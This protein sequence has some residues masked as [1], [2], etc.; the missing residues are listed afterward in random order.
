MRAPAPLVQAEQLEGE[1][2]AVSKMRVTEESKLRATL[3]A[4]EEAAEAARVEA[5]ANA[6]QRLAA[7]QAHLEEMLAKQRAELEEDL[8]KQLGSKTAYLEGKNQALEAELDQL[9]AELKKYKNAEKLS[10]KSLSSAAAQDVAAA[11]VRRSTDCTCCPPLPPLSTSAY[12]THLPKPRA[13]L[14]P[15]HL[16]NPEQGTGKSPCPRPPHFRLFCA[17]RPL[18]HA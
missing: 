13:H 2:D 15:Y 18:A 14:A 9:R 11:E 3:A 17:A 6:D 4:A 16:I 8:A 10:S 5:A 12:V 7:A 1:I